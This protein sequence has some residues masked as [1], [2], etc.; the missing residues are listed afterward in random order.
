MKKERTITFK[1]YS[2][3]LK[4]NKLKFIVKSNKIR[5]IWKKYKQYM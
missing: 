1:P 3:K 2:R 4:R 5:A